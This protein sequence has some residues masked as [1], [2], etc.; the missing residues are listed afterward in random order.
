MP[1]PVS[2]TRSS[3]NGPGAISSACASSRLDLAI[4]GLD[5]QASA[6]RHGV[7]GVEREVDQ[8]LFELRGIG[9]HRPQVRRQLQIDRDV[10]ADQ[11]VEHAAHVG[12][13]LVEH[14]DFRREDL[15][16]AEREQLSGQRRRAIGR[17]EDLLDV[18]LERRAV[19]LLQQQLGI[20]ADRGQQVVEVVRDAAREPP[21]ASIFCACR[22]C[23][24][25]WL[26]ADSAA[27]RSAI[28]RRSS[29][30][31]RPSAA[32]RSSTRRSR[33]RCASCSASWLARSWRLGVVT[34]R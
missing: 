22:S 12:D 27:C 21:I 19:Q 31:A 26:R 9:A 13:A 28:S 7:A 4:G 15:P 16:P 20:A 23:S 6:L 17:V 18:G 30:L 33:S 1:T 32:V 25:S 29:S 2:R 5:R 24:S 34:A 3:T 10:L 8:H 14:D 11:A